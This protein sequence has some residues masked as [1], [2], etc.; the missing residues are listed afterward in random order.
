[1][2]NETPDKIK[3]INRIFHPQS[4]AV[5]GANK[6]KG[7]VPADILINI[8]KAEFKG[9]VYPVNPKESHISSI[10]TYKYVID[11]D[12]PVDLAVIVYPSSVMHMAL[13][14]CGQK[15]IKSAIII[16]AGFK[17]VGGQGIE[18]EE[19][20]K[21]IAKKYGISFIG[22]NCLGV[23]NT[24]PSV[25]LDASFARKMPEEG[26]IA[27]IS[28]SGALCTAVLDYAQAKHIG[29]SKFVSIGN[30]ADISEIDLL[31]YLKDD[32]KTKVILLYLEE[33][34][35]GPG[36]MN[37]ARTVIEQ[38][39]KPILALKSG[40]TSAGASAAASHT[41]SLAGSDEICDAAF[42]QSG[43]IRCDDIEE[44]FN[45]AIAFTYQ[46]LP[47]SNRISIVTNAGG[48]GVLTTDAAIKYGLE[49]PKFSAETTSILKKSLPKTANINNPVD[50]IGD[51][52]ADRY[53]VAVT[54]I[55]KDP[56]V[57]GVFVI[58]TPQ[59][60][61][62]IESIATEISHL[63]SQYEK[64]I[65]TSFMGEADVAA[66]IDILQRNK[67][68]HYILP[69]SMPISFATTYK[70]KKMIEEI[71][72]PVETFN[73]VNQ[74]AAHSVLNKAI[75]EG[76]K[77]L[78]EEEAAKVLEAY[79]FPMLKSGLAKSKKEAIEL[80]EILGYPVVMKIMSDEIVHKFDIGGVILD[81]KS[82][83]EAAESYKKII[84]NVNKNM[85]N[86]NIKGVFV[87]RMIPPGE[88][89][90]LGLKRDIT[91]GPVIMFGLGGIF[92]EIYKDV[93]FRIAPL[94]KKSVDNLITETK[95]SAILSGARGRTP[96][97]INS[98]KHCIMR[99]SQL[100]VD[101]P[102]IRELDINPLIVLEDGKGSFVADTK[103][104]L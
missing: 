19:Q 80:S 15:G 27:F 1:M 78:P 50:V 23:I 20:I 65:Y 8:L 34:G 87:R 85:P 77:Y 43:I 55:L 18:R 41:G 26:N 47:K 3:N 48:P 24:D 99:L 96:R 100:A 30:K 11:I 17:E 32:P 35:D 4:I 54:S 72:D 61:T 22:P 36:L 60:M 66:G 39:G 97:D 86:A 29:F 84:E 57:D 83:D 7:T 81:I 102:Q 45:K 90:I 79:N 88:E 62:E 69:E 98:I 14:Q 28:Q 46:P 92:V 70:F 9:V 10:K 94:D 21:E 95:A 67:I 74:E 73:D 59:S 38:T 101:C 103:I 33:I 2:N 51:A 91:F 52:R 63:A 104:M 6:V 76:K 64:P 75:N 89:V 58:L 68:P 71:R 12:D 37:A 42:K 82:K 31:Y 56:N 25:R 16:S 53:N 5:L 49:L 13:E 44:M 40:R 93:S